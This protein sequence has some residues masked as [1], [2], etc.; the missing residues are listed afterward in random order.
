MK[1]RPRK[2]GGVLFGDYYS[3]GTGWPAP[4]PTPTP[5]PDPEPTPT[6]TPTPIETY[7]ITLMATNGSWNRSTITEIANGTEL[8]FDIT[9]LV[10]TIGNQT[11]RFIPNEGYIYTSITYAEQY[12]TK[13]GIVRAIASIAPTPTPTG[14]TITLL[15]TN[16]T[17]DTNSITA[18]NGTEYSFNETTLTL[19]VGNQTA[20][21]TPKNGSIY[22]GITHSSGIL[23]GDISIVATANPV[24]YTVTLSSQNGSWNKLS[25][26]DIPYGTNYSFD[27]YTKTLTVGNQTAVFTPDY[28]D[29]FDNYI[30]NDISSSSGSITSNT[31]ITAYA[32]FNPNIEE[33]TGSVFIDNNDSDEAEIYF[34]KTPDKVKI[35]FDILGYSNTNEI[36]SDEY[37]EIDPDE[38]IDGIEK[39]ISK[40]ERDGI[41]TP[42]YTGYWEYGE[43][44]IHI[45]LT[46]D[47][48]TL[49]VVNSVD[50]NDGKTVIEIW[51][52][53]AI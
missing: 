34:S 20:V 5:V 26:V 19:T 45:N 39:I 25:F 2:F 46:N 41:Y 29:E 32:I 33:I 44:A 17:W 36:D 16:G 38:Y 13:D 6:P 47:N 51:K 9:T 37:S 42:E 3:G 12:I 30:Y 11:A 15:G 48:L 52:M 10:L 7:T 22:Y 43:L 50:G 31:T 14:S 18:E 23:D 35:W 53:R 28:E 21:F 27:S 49:S 1:N 24:L 40:D 8:S 4:A